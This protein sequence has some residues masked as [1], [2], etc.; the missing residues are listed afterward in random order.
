M[1]RLARVFG[2]AFFVLAMAPAA[3]SQAKYDPGVTLWPR[4]D[5]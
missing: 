3:N 5:A 4:R 1:S 2:M